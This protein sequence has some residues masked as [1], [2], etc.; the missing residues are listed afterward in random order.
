MIKK[1]KILLL[2]CFLS[3]VFFAYSQGEFS[4]TRE[5]DNYNLNVFSAKLNSNGFGLNY[6]FQMRK[7]YRL[8]RVFETEYNY[9]IDIKEVKVVNPQFQLIS[10]KPF[11][12]GKLYSAHNLNFGYGYNRMFFEKRDN[13]SISIHLLTTIGISLCFLK[14]IY[15]QK[16][17]EKEE[18]LYY[19]KFDINSTTI[20]NI[21]GKASFFMG[22]KEIK[23]VPGLY[24]KLGAEFDFAKDIMQTSVLSAG[25]EL[26]AY[27]KQIEIMVENKKFL[28]PSFYIMYSF[29]KKY[30]SKLNREYRRAMKKKS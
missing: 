27:M 11:V 23:V 28:L 24:V 4:L 8:R 30:D 5:P 2:G 9:L 21:M 20:N 14:P 22:I 13:N 12:L 25:I 19:E 6:S 10:N 3:G 29:G 15:Y 17:D 16:F 18:K 1:R 26:Q 7:F